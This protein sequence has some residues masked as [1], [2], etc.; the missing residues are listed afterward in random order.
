MDISGNALV[1]GGGS[2]IGRACAILF[3]KEGA[4]G[5]LVADV[6]LEAAT[7]VAAECR[8]AATNEQFRAVAVHVDITQEDSVRTVMALMAEIFGRM[9]YCVNC[10]GIGAQEGVDIAGISLAEFQRF[11]D[12]NTTGMFL[13]TRE[14]SILMRAQEPLPVS[15]SSPGRGVSRG[16][17]VNLGS[18]CS[19]IATPGILPYTTSKHAVLGLCKNSALDNAPYA[20]RVNCVCPSW[21]DTP[22]V[23]RAMDGVE[24]LAKLIEAAVPIG[25]MALPEEVADAVI[26]L[27]SPRS[28]YVTGCGFIIDGGTTVT[29]MR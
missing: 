25:R 19:V 15:I 5:V 1:V 6:N 2:G 8:A 18:G 24:G 11:L 21:T 16:S 20:I 29:A 13:V 14:A 17:I 28:S 22:I 27:S 4:A 23:R 7:E 12:V 9:E 3:A 26:F 10:A